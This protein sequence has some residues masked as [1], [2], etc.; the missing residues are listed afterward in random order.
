MVPRKLRWN[1]CHG[2]V[3]G[4]HSGDREIPFLQGEQL[5]AQ[6]LSPKK[7]A[8]RE[9]TG[10]TTPDANQRVQR[11]VVPRNGTFNNFE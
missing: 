5:F 2:A 3:D 1:L 10:S 9:Y 6:D 11:I 7:C 8:P 4:L